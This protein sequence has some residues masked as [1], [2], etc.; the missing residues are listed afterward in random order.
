MMFGDIRR[1]LDP[2][3]WL[4]D[5]GF[6]PYPW[7]QRAM[8]SRS[9]RKAWN[10]HR[11]AAKTTTAGAKAIANASGNTGSLTICISPSQR[12]SSEW[13]RSTVGLYHRIPGLP[14]LVAESAHR[15][16]FT[17]GSR[18]LS[19]PSSEATI[20][21]FAKCSLLILDE[22]SRIPD[23]IIDAIAPALALATDNEVVALSTPWGRRGKFFEW[24]ER[25]EGAWE[26]ETLTASESGIIDPEFL[27]EQRKA[28]GELLY[29]QEYECRFVDDGSQLFST[30]MIEAC[31]VSSEEHR[32]WF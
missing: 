17:G 20:R 23:D 2:T 21:G 14:P 27:A 8:C 1:S 3:L 10:L 24:C 9:R 26:V 18:I 5:A 30:E 6:D 7:Q 11:Q 4:R 19:L 22:C 32:P 13:L 29:S 16:E 25:G 15:V 31:I 28:M 12:Q